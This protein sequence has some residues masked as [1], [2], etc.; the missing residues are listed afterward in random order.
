MLRLAVGIACCIFLSSCASMPEVS[1]AVRA[2]LAP[3]GTLRVGINYGNFAVATK[4]PVTGELRGVAVDLIQ[5][6]GRR[7][8][9][10]V[11]MIGWPGA[12]P[13]LEGL[14]NGTLDVGYIAHEIS[15]EGSVSFTR[16]YFEVEGTYLVPPGSP[17]RSVEDVDREGVRIGVSAKSAYESYLGR[18]LKHARLVGAPGVPATAELLYSGQVDAM[19]GQK[20]RLVA[21]GRKL[22]GSRVLDG[23]FQTVRQA[24]AMP[25]SREAGIQYLRGFIEEAHASGF[26]A[27][28]MEKHGSAAPD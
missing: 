2:D 5:E 24:L 1:P 9:V 13:V 4:D 25:R 22:P 10:P 23:S 20:H 27:R 7:A 28:S 3:T 19:A 26:I 17:L 14:L 18:T 8:G 6:V 12:A 21:A 16:S 15:R 11:D